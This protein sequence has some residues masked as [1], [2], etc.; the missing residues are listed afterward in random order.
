MSRPFPH[1]LTFHGRGLSTLLPLSSLS[2]C[3]SLA[4]YSFIC[5]FLMPFLSLTL[6]FFYSVNISGSM[7]FSCSSGSLCVNFCIALPLLLSISFNMFFPFHPCLFLPSS[8]PAS[9]LSTS[10]YLPP[11]ILFYLRLFLAP[12]VSIYLCLSFPDQHLY[13]YVFL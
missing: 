9:V 12:F 11:S 10:L 2:L 4:L 13:F 6:S 1:S 8:S 5:L 7:S 3:A